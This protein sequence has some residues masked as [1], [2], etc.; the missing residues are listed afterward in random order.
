MRGSTRTS[1][2]AAYVA[3]GAL[4]VSGTILAGTPAEA[5]P[6]DPVG[7]NEGATWVGKE[8][9]NGLFHYPDNGFGAYDEYGLSIDAAL[10]LKALG[11]HDARVESV[12]TAIAENVNKYITGEAFGDAGSTYAGAVA[13]TMVLAQS[14]GGNP[15]SFGG[16][17]LQSRLEGRVSSTAPIAGRLEDVSTYG[18]SANTL[19][20]SFAANGLS[21][22]G[23]TK[24]ADVTSFLLKQQCSTGYF[25]LKFTADKTAPNQ[26]C[27]DGTD[28]PDTDATAIAV[29]QLASQS[30][31]GTVNT[32][33]GKAKAWLVAQQESDGSW[34]GGAST[35]D[36]NAN[37]T[38]LAAWALGD[39]PQS[40][41]AAEWL[42]E[43]QVTGY[44]ACDKLSSQR[45]AIA[46]NGSSFA[47]GRT[48]GITGDTS[49]QWRRAS[50]QALPGL[51]YLPQDTT[52]SN[53]SLTGPSGYLK[54]GTSQVLTTRGVQTG[55][56]LC[57]S[58]PNTAFKGTA[59]GTSW[60]KT[61]TLPAGTAARRYAVRDTAGHGA[62]STLKVLGKKTLSVRTSKQR[63]KRSGRVSVTVSGLA[64]GERA[65]IYYK[66]A[67]KRSATASSTGRL[68]ASFKVGRALGRKK[69]TATGQFSDIRRGTQIIRVV[70]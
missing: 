62:T 42:R 2:I 10:A 44:N 41:R 19:G 37:S 66:G 13:K 15:S 49:D 36:P 25:R 1:R 22:A 45:G 61:V 59:S 9:T 35:E 31:N 16:V 64:S 14:T 50:A 30:G 67:L 43:N 7:I 38:G 52:P 3:S 28:V 47:A 27:V 63:V 55:D 69:I 8:L 24:N 53:P 21:T 40:E 39:T 12:R 11:G 23:S 6:H 56:Q 26:S 34:G 58:G 5:A 48:N 18:D 60:A 54:A 57:L 51:A 65:R 29:L 4:V 68:T 17:N 33:I 20:Q 32:A 70:R 46:Y